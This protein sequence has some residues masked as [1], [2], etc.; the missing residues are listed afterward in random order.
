[1]HTTRL[2][3]TGAVLFSL[4]GAA[5]AQNNGGLEVITVTAMKKAQS[6]QDVPISVSAVTSQVLE[7]RGFK[8]FT[9]LQSVVPN[10]QIDNTNGN[11][12]ITVR[13][14][15]SGI[16]N[17]AFEQS[18]GLFNDGVY[19]SRAR[20]MQVPFMDVERIE[21]V[22]GPQGALFGKNTNAGAIS[23]I[24]RKPTD[25]FQAEVRASGEMAVGGYAFSGFVSGPLADTLDARV[26]GQIGH[27][28]AYIENRLTGQDEYD[29]DYYALRGQLAWAP[30]ENF[31]ALLKAE[32]FSSYTHG[33]NML[34]NSMG[35]EPGDPACPRCL[36]ERNNSGG[37]NAQIYPGFWRTA[38]SMFP[39]RNRTN[40]GNI[41]LTANWTAGEW[42][43]TSITAYQQLASLQDIDPTG[44]GSSFLFTNQIEHSNQFS[45][46]VRVDRSFGDDLDV[47]FGIS[48]FS[49]KL[50]L[51]QTVT[52]N[53][54]AA[55][56]AGV[57]TGVSWRP[58]FQ[59][60]ESISPYLLV[61]YTL[62]PNLHF[63]GSLRYSSEEKEADIIQ[64][65]SG[66]GFPASNLPYNL[67]GKINE[68][69]WD[70]SAK[71]RY[72]FDTEK[73]VYASYATGTKA[74]GFVSNNATLLFDMRNSGATLDFKSE[75]AKSWEIGAKA[76]F[77][78]GHADLNL[79]LFY[80]DFD[81]LQVSRYNGVTFVTQN[82][83]EAY[84]QGVELEGNYRYNADLGAGGSIAYLDARYADFPGGACLYNAPPSC[85]PATN[86]LKGSPLLRAPAWKGSFY[87]SLGR[88]LN[89]TLR[90]TSRL[91]V[92][93]AS[94]SWLQP[95]L[96]PLNS[97]PSF[98]KFDARIA[99]APIEDGW[100]ISLTGKNLTNEVTWGQAL[101]PP[102]IAG[103][104]HLVMVNP[105]RTITLEGVLRF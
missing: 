72:E 104:A 10:L 42:Q 33:N 45:Q 30:T 60:G 9:D 87:L 12:A 71:L 29:Q 46:E 90:L 22:R 91:S 1:M 44:G 8:E 3:L 65:I 84:T 78:D 56:F 11:F 20:T 93:F 69:L 94:R 59:T 57:M 28:G 14:L 16:G 19:S 17:L 96:N 43:I 73:S 105:P 99:L 98:A 62:L 63:N 70:Y 50:D 25:E 35:L 31:N 53:G 79:A 88:D 85:S 2:I 6:L 7:Q 47:S 75:L 102:V 41:T 26:S 86:N 37:V 101:V 95:D 92:D 15:G 80:T 76:R 58:I 100:E 38:R 64:T 103:N 67:H 40:S 89:D 97:M 24:T 49:T 36:A 21:V 39:E 23:I 54:A 68:P 61:D 34:F 52:Y 4:S 66:T 81:N 77:L 32:G 74:G 83:A 48:Y 13:G 51:A 55:P 82:A 5:F 27:N 18:V